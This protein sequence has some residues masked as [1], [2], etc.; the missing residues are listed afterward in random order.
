MKKLTII[1][2]GAFTLLFGVN[3]KGST[4]YTLDTPIVEL[5]N[6]TLREVFESGNLVVNGDF[7]DGT[8]GWNILRGGINDGEY[9][10]SSNLSYDAGALQEINFEIGTYY[11][12]IKARNS[13]SNIAY[14]D[15]SNSIGSSITIDNTNME[16]K[17][18]FF[19]KS[20]SEI[21]YISLGYFTVIDT[22]GNIYFD[23]I[24]LYNLTS[25]GISSL[26]QARMDYWFNVYQDLLKDIDRVSQLP[27][28]FIDLFNE[29]TDNFVI[30]IKGFTQLIYLD[31][32]GLTDLG[33]ISLIII[34][35][36]VI[37]VAIY[38]IR[39]VI[40]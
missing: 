19:D 24:S 2:I 17:S 26:S 3:V 29:I 30:G 6:H 25:F 10:Y 11:F 16:Y 38:I 22:L 7:S 36:S 14:A 34:S 28:L 23:E 4:L 20:I 31:G 37:G 33:I 5:N 18:S 1:I 35:I 21:R 32:Y 9:A 40:K 13:S 39:K 15:I 27:N 12:V 8:T